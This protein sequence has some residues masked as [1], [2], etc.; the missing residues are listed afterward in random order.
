M[1]FNSVAENRSSIACL[2]QY[3]LAIKGSSLS[4]YLS[5]TCIYKER[6]L[7]PVVRTFMVG[8]PKWRF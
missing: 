4:A 2:G 7:V 3:F 6:E 5:N 8:H 1:F